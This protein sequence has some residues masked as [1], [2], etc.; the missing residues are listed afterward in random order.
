[1]TGTTKKSHPEFSAMLVSDPIQCQQ[2]I[3]VN[4]DPTF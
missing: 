4:F 1:M 2:G 3:G